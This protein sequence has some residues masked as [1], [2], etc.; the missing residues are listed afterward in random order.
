MSSGRNTHVSVDDIL[1]YIPIN[2]KNLKEKSHE[3]FYSKP[4]AGVLLP[5]PKAQFFTISFKKNAPP[6]K[7]FKE[8]Y[9]K[10]FFG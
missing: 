9:I 7:P 3:I 8:K 4:K 2:K 10:E 1:L 6:R 5:K